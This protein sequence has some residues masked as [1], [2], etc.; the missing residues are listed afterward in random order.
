MESYLQKAT[1]HQPAGD[2][3]KAFLNLLAT[4]RLGYL[5]VWS[6]NGWRRDGVIRVFPLT[7]QGALD[8][9]HLLEKEVFSRSSSD[10]S[11]ADAVVRRVRTGS[12]KHI[13][14]LALVDRISKRFN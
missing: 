2:T 11:S 14:L 1:V 13:A 10:W 7:E 6:W 3:V 8:T 4:R 9:H 5:I 12:P